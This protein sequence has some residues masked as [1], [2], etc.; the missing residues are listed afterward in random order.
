MTNTI[1]FKETEKEVFEVLSEIKSKGF[2]RSGS[3]RML[4]RV[5]GC[6]ITEDQLRTICNYAERGI[7]QYTN[8]FEAIREDVNIELESV[9]KEFTFAEAMK[10]L[11]ESRVSI[12]IV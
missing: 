12:R 7:E 6:K 3:L 5:G 1:I 2:S 9:A 8:I 10:E 4:T 11:N